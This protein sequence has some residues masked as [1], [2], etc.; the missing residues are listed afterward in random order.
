MNLVIHLQYY[1]NKCNFNSIDTRSNSSYRI[2]WDEK[3]CIM[4]FKVEDDGEVEWE[5]QDLD[6]D[7]DDFLTGNSRH[8]QIRSSQKCF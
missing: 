3:T 5:F 6:F 7:V 8:T 1:I 4:R 2:T